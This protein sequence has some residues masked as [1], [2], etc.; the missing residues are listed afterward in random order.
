MASLHDDVPAVQDA[1]HVDDV[2]VLR[3]FR[4]DLRDCMTQRGDAL[5]EAMDAMLCAHGPVQSPVEL[6][7]EPEFRRGHGSVYDALAHGKI[8]TARLRRVLV[9]AVAPS[10]P[11]EPLLFA[12]DTTPLARPDAEYADERVMVQVRGK[13]GDVYLPGWHYSMLVGLR[14]GSFIR[15]CQM[16]CVT[17]SAER[18]GK[19]SSENAEGV[20]R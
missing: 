19:I 2:G 8:D 18:A 17:R 15:G 6:S 5:F 7:V 3:R 10:R 13:G 4:E 9:D 14:W 20:H 12:I 1:P 11:G 16:V